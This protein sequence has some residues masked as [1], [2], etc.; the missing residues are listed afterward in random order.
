[1][2]FLNLKHTW[3]IVRAHCPIQHW[4]GERGRDCRSFLRSWSSRGNCCR[5]EGSL[6]DCYHPIKS[7]HLWVTTPKTDRPAM[8]ITGSVLL[9]NVCGLTGSARSKKRERSTTA[10]KNL[11]FQEII[12]F[13][14]KNIYKRSSILK[15]IS[16][17]W[18]LAWLW[19]NVK[20]T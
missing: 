9:S 1:M 8:K 13:T 7:E 4:T 19:G 3:Q 6:S 11:C 5:S 15:I 12:F 2:L 14:Q 17:M 18:H 16:I 10:S 20:Y